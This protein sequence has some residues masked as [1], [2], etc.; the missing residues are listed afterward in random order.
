MKEYEYIVLATNEYLSHLVAATIC[1]ENYHSGENFS[2]FFKKLFFMFDELRNDFSKRY[3]SSEDDEILIAKAKTE[4]RISREN[5]LKNLINDLN[6]INNSIDYKEEIKKYME[7]IEKEDVETLEM[8]IMLYP[9]LISLI[10]NT[11]EREQN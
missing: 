5:A 2:E 4:F 1:M 10:R 11:E 8:Q 3:T 6:S 9:H 7:L